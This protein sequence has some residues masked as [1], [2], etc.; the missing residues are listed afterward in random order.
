MASVE[1][2]SKSAI[3]NQLRHIERTIQNPANKDI[4][5]ERSN[6]N[7]SL[8]DKGMSSYDYYKERLS[9]CYL[10][11]RD[12]VKTCFGWVITCPEDVTK[13][14]EDLFFYNCFDFLNER[15]GEE[16]CI[17]AVV[18]KD[19]SG[20]PHLHYYAIPV[21]PDKKHE[22]GQKVCMNDV[23]NKKEL[24]NFHPD[25]D[26]FLKNRGMSCGVYTG[27]TRKNGGNMTVRQLKAEREVKQE[28]QQKRERKWEHVI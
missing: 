2:F 10:Y 8:I 27:I 19:E 21:V 15:Y 11:N 7:Y 24:R 14:D 25:L 1:K 12:D 3:V 6:L 23:I 17:Q 9:Q 13:E 5:K 20:R 26:R 28:V 22:Q 16:N 4:D 18:H